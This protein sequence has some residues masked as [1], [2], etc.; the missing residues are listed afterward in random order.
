M[1]KNK[2][3][4]HQQTSLELEHV[5]EEYDLL[6]MQVVDEIA[7]LLQ[8]KHPTG[9]DIDANLAVEHLENYMEQFYVESYQKLPNRSKAL[10]ALLNEPLYF[11]DI[12]T[13]PGWIGLRLPVIRHISN[14]ETLNIHRMLREL[15]RLRVEIAK[16]KQLH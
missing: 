14:E 10:E 5:T 2:Q 15:K 7:R 13:R 16:R 9:W 4:A 3:L 11:W 12:F 8:S 1:S 6:R